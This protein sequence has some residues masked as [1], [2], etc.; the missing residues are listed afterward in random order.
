MK[1][2]EKIYRIIFSRA[3]FFLAAMLVQLL[4]LLLMFYWF[5]EYINYF[6]WVSMLCAL[7]T[8]IYILNKEGSSEYKIAWLI[9]IAI[10]PAAG[11]LLYVLLNLQYKSKEI[12]R[13]ASDNDDKIKLLLRQSDEVKDEINA[14]DKHVGNLIRYMNNCS[15]Y[16]IYKNTSSTFFKV[17]EEKFDSLIED[18]K[19]AKKFIFLEYFIIARGNL[20][21]GILQ[22][23]KEKA[24][25]G[26]EV[27]VMYDGMCEVQSLPHEYYKVL[28]RYNIKVKVINPVLPVMSTYQNNRD[29]RKIAVIDG[30]IAYT[31]GI[32][33]A[34]EYINE[35]ERFG[36]WKDTAIRLEGE[37]VS[38]FTL[39]FLAM[40][41]IYE[42]TPIDYKE[43]MLDY[44]VESD[45]YVMP[46]ADSPLDV[47]HISKRIY[48]D[49]INTANEYVHIETPYL[50][51]D[52]EMSSSLK[53]AAKRGVD[54]KILMPH[55]PD[56]KYAFYLA[57]SYYKELLNAGVKIYEYT[58]G[59][60]HSKVFIS[61]NIEAVV[62]TVN[63]DYRSL[64]L[65]F[66][67]AT[68]LYKTSSIKEIE[69][70]FN[71]TLENSI[72]ITL[73]LYKKRSIIK[74]IYGRLLRLFAPL[75]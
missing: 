71:K 53:Y 30:K 55:I 64:Y 37:A 51:L 17:G 63:L 56:K 65:H 18:L 45:G 39:M 59:F 61:D 31:G 6:Y 14:K 42:R 9:P 72:E 38:S 21:D 58:P 68:Y 50:I 75:M 62:G 44:K 22:I 28:R 52:D 15:P 24:R 73:T 35:L 12:G 41:N 26:I 60:V 1:I 70:D 20:W 32:N 33:I 2:V 10:F 8:I 36:H 27:R 54:V 5:Y 4:L 46:Y 16:T 3:T 19:N 34:D 67:C 57:Q 25:E 29:H 74:K 69:R 23:L 11:I 66:E 13:K 47:N 40:W 48:L 43:Y 7:G 49:I